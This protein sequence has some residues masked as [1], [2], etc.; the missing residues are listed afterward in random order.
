MV[1]L[2]SLI[3]CSLAGYGFGGWTSPDG[4]IS[5][6]TKTKTQTITAT[7][8]K[9]VTLNIYANWKTATVVYLNSDGGNDNLNDGLSPETPF[10]SWSRAYEYLYNNSQDRTDRENNIIV[11]T[12][13]IDSTMH[14][15]RTVTGSQTMLADVTYES[16]T[17]FTSGETITKTDGTGNNWYLWIIAKIRC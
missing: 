9:N 3:V 4:I 1:T 7:G 5:T 13:N 11:L 15:S 8:S 10:G 16:S 17:T 14:G 2:L 6:D 12:G